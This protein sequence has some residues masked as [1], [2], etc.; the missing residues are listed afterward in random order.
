M[1]KAKQ[2]AAGDG[3]KGVATR[4]AKKALLRVLTP[5]I[6]AAVAVIVVVAAMIIVIASLAGGSAAEVQR[7]GS[8]AAASGGVKAEDENVYR[9]IANSFGIPWEILAALPIAEASSG[10]SAGYNGPYAIKAGTPGISDADAAKLGPAATFIAGRMRAQMVISSGGRGVVYHQDSLITGAAQDTDGTLTYA[11]ASDDV[12]K[13][14]AATKV[15]F[16]GAMVTLPVNNA[17]QD[18]MGTTFDTAQA[19]ALG[20][21]LSCAGSSVSGTADGVQIALPQGAVAGLT[22][23]QTRN[24]AIVYNAGI[25]AKMGDRGA[26]IGI[27]V[28]LAESTLMNFANDGTSEDQGYFSDGHRQLNASER[29]VAKLSL[30]YPHDKVGHN[31]DSIGLFQQRPSANW[32]APADLIDQAKS[33]AIFFSRLI[34][35]SGWA[36]TDTPWAA[37]QTVQGSPSSDGAIYQQQYTL[38]GTIIAALKST[39]TVGA[40]GA[41]ASGVAA[42]GGAAVTTTAGPTS[43]PAATTSS[44][45]AT[46][47]AA[48]GATPAMSYPL[49]ATTGTTGVEE[50]VNS[51]GQ[52]P[53]GRGVGTITFSKFAA[54]GDDYD[55]YYITMRWN[56]VAWNYNGTS[57]GVDNA[58]YNWFAAAPRMVLVTNP[59]TGKSIIAPAMESGPAPW[60]G[61][62]SGPTDTDTTGIW[63]NPTRGTPAGYKGIVSG[64]P[65]KAIAALG[66]TPGYLGQAGDSL[67]YQWAPDQSAKPGPT[68]LIAKADG[69]NTGTTGGSADGCSPPCPV[70]AVAVSGTS[71]SSTPATTS[72]AVSA[73]ASSAAVSSGALTETNPAINTMPCSTGGSTVVSNGPNITLPDNPNIAQQLR[74]K[75]IKA[76]TTQ[77]AAGLIWALQNT[78]GVPYIYGGGGLGSTNPGGPDNGMARGAG[79]LNAG[80]GTGYDCSGLSWTVLFHMSPSLSI[81]DGNSGAMASGGTHVPYAQLLPGDLITFNGHVAVSLG[82][83]DGVVIILEAPE[84]GKGVRILPMFRTDE[85]NWVSRYWTPVAAGTSTTAATTATVPPK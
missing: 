59:R 69:T 82:T 78:L 35:V 81:P 57:T 68:T 27:A 52:V 11:T 58:Q 38:A 18:F 19:W 56:Y 24:A 37:G 73:P 12:I 77:V 30:N 33:A 14:S 48:A 84:P 2:A 7:I 41:A 28:A 79:E 70:V 21:N 4:S 53:S 25:A 23:V 76:P 55:N 72:A 26:Q 32:G 49:P 22:D 64:F 5:Y 17:T 1:A 45:A 36:T 47:T 85:N 67:V 29:A 31:L 50:A 9:P 16:V 13:A 54:L 62:A 8:V 43:T 75:V 39:K 44:I 60:V 34:G 15:A 20:K 42:S 71:G 46:G 63:K 61:V 83:I 74:G 66:A 65:P 3:F 40:T 6:A 10:A 51:A 80:T